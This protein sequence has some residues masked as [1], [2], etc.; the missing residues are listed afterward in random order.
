MAR[1]HCTHSDCRSVMCFRCHTE[2][3]DESKV[4]S[5]QEEAAKESKKREDEHQKNKKGAE[6]RG[7][8]RVVHNKEDNKS[9]KR[10]ARSRATSSR[11][12]RNIMSDKTETN[13]L[14]DDNF[15]KHDDENSWQREADFCYFQKAYR[16]KRTIMGKE[17]ELLDMHCM[18][19]GGVM[20]HGR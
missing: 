18:K 20:P 19:C 2:W 11:T 3:V 5:N 10:T 1:G 17:G 9:K 8:A 14:P 4:I 7:K 16:D 12:N 15:C 13:H 6:A